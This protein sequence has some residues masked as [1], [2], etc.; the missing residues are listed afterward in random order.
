MKIGVLTY[1]RI[2]NTGAVIQAYAVT[3]IMQDIFPSAEIEIIDLFPLTMF[4]KEHRKRVSLR[5]LKMNKDFIEKQEACVD[6]ISSSMR[7]SSKR[8]FFNNGKKAAKWIDTLGYDLVVVG[9]DT[10]WE[11]R[12]PGYAPRGVNPYVLPYNGGYLKASIS[13][14][15]DPIGDTDND[16]EVE[17][18]QRMKW[19]EKF[20]YLSV[21]DNA[22]LDFVNQYKSQDLNFNLL[23][24]P[25]LINGLDGFSDKSALDKIPERILKSKLGGVSMSE[26]YAPKAYKF[27]KSMGYKTID[28]G[29]RNK[30]LVDYATPAD[31]SVQQAYAVHSCLDILITDRFHA[32]IFT[33]LQCEAPVFF[34]EDPE[35]WKYKNSKGRDL[36][37]LLGV[38]FM[39]FRDISLAA[40]NKW[41]GEKM[42]AWQKSLPAIEKNLK[43]IK[44]E[45]FSDIRNGLLE[46]T[47]HV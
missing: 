23:P 39:V 45:G 5:Q 38:E 40:D 10:V 3:K 11:L 33:I 41:V 47:K 43:T 37:K 26:N 21:R 14:S 36:F 12:K 16:Q 8:A 2:V 22:T 20:D 17:F 42:H 32:S 6:F 15:M 29:G 9:S 35:K 7:L 31:F 30:K 13:A 18:K 34:Y 1:H 44:H 28:V 4:Y 24:D 46:I 27:L 19:I 25:T